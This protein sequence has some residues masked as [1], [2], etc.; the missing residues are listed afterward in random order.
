[1]K[2]PYIDGGGN[3]HNNSDAHL[4]DFYGFKRR[5]TINAFSQLY[6]PQ[7][8]LL[9]NKIKQEKPAEYQGLLN[10]MRKYDDSEEG[11]YISL[12]G[13]FPEHFKD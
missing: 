12:A 9:L 1:M 6:W 3:I 5:Q 8:E 11:A 2:R 7:V 13:Q 4:E 10:I